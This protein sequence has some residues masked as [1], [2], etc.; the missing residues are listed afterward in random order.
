MEPKFFTSQF[1][2]RAEEFK[3]YLPVNINLRFETVASPLILCEETYIRPLLGKTLFTALAEFVGNNPT[4]PDGNPKSDLVDKVRFALLRLAIWKD[5]DVI[6]ANISDT[7][8]SSMVDKEN[9]L[10]RYQ[11]ENLKT[12]LKEEG[13]NYLDS[14]LEFLEEKSQDFPEFEHSQ[15]KLSN[16]DSLIRNTAQ[17]Q[18]C[19]DIGGSRLVF[20][21]MRDYIRDVE[22]IELQHRIG[23]EFFE[24]LL[25]ADESDIKYGTILPAIRHY[26]VYAALAEGIGE[27]HKMPTEK[28]LVFETSTMDGVQITP[29]Y[30][31]QVME[32][33][34]RFAQRAEQYL[35]CALHTIGLHPS[36]YPNYIN[37]AG[38]SPE[39]GVIHRDNTD[40][41]IFLA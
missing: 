26:V 7:G 29:V 16:V 31:A 13:F 1:N 3:R 24:E 35:A 15:Y 38:N 20:L 18:Q 21:K 11:E 34:A 2:E 12:T 32:S 22:H 4:L 5:Y 8:V 23:H 30:R 19:Y 33:R 39:D 41:K 10:F 28:G 17:F 37:F 27:L 36:N 40:R 9:R 6:A 14:I 25:E